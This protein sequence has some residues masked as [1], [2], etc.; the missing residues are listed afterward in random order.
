MSEDII[1][2][3]KA[4]IAILQTEIRLQNERFAEMQ[5]ALQNERDLK[6]QLVFDISK[7]RKERFELIKL[8]DNVCE[9]VK[10][11][12]VPYLDTVNIYATIEDYKKFVNSPLY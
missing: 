6:S 3:Y 2:L 4:E 8:A 5:N 9:S 7:L 10:L 11:A 12:E 1:K